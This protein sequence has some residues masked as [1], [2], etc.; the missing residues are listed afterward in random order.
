MDFG[1]ERPASPSK[2]GAMSMFNVISFLGGVAE[3]DFSFGG[4]F[5]PGPLT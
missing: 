5:M 3:F 1:G 2:V 4:G